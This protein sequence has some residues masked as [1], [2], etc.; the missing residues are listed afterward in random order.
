MRILLLL[1]VLLS[2]SITIT[3]QNNMSLLGHIDFSVT[4]NSGCSNLWGYVDETGKEYAIVGLVKGTSIV[5]ISDPANPMEVFFMPDST[6]TWREVKVWQDYAYI[7]TE[8]DAG[9]AIIDLSP[10]PFSTALTSY[11]FFG[12]AG[13][14]F[15]RAHSLNIDENGILY[16]HGADRGNG[17][18][19]F[20]DLTVDP[21]NPPEVGSYDNYYIHD[22]YARGDTLY[23][24][25]VYD[26]FFQVI[27]VSD[28]SNPVVLAQQTTPACFTH[29][30]WLSDD[31]KYLFTTDEVSNASIASYD[32]SDLG[33]ITELDQ[34]R[35]NPG[36]GSIP[37][38][39]YYLSG[40]WIVTSY[41]R[42]GVV[43]HDAIDPSN[44]I[45]V[46]QYDVSPTSGNGFSSVWGVYPYFPS[47]IIIAS[48][49]QTGLYIFSANYQRGAY[50]HGNVSDAS[51]GSDIYNA[52]VTILNT[53]LAAYTGINGNYQH[54][55]GSTGMYDVA[56][57]KPGYAR[58]TVYNVSLVQG[59]TSVLDIQLQPLVPISVSGQVTEEGSGL[60]IA[61]AIV[62]FTNNEFQLSVT[63]D[64]AGNYMIS[65]AFPGTY[66]LSSGHWG[67][68]NY[69][70]DS[71]VFSGP[72]NICNIQLK[73]GYY[74][75]FQLE[76]GWIIDASAT[77][78]NWTRATP[79]ATG[80][81][82]GTATNPHFDVMNDCGTKAFVTGN[83]LGTAGAA[84]VDGGPTRLSSPLFDATTYTD[85]WLAYSRWFFNNDGQVPANDTFF[86]YISNG[87]DTVLAE[88]LT[89]QNAVTS[90]WVETGFQIASLI[91]PT[92]NM[93]LILSVEDDL[94]AGANFLEAGIDRFY[95]SE[96]NQLAVALREN[97]GEIQV[98]P[99]P[100]QETIT[101]TIPENGLGKA[102][103]LTDISGKILYSGIIRLASQKL[104][105]S[106]YA[107]GIYI[108]RIE[109]HIPVKIIKH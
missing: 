89:V 74:D 103:L 13:N 34:V 17:G 109:N 65:D 6:S 98:Y 2:F 53:N 48:D 62:E 32:I 75:D 49:M 47:G 68:W 4:R 5:D 45:E 86:I 46:A 43:I 19:I 21:I 31:G 77:G 79:I 58:D 82:D 60:P 54:G 104:D 92:A 73:K 8:E 72:V 15:T 94:S 42:D 44:L 81:P 29:N 90:Q 9:M 10:L 101:I 27:D 59:D 24:A 26:G 97:N 36:S 7:T 78:G 14:G 18:A 70:N 1:F 80:L 35:S 20:Y 51:N 66:F 30:C 28:K 93:R 33:N 37:H 69:C 12:D 38:N 61:N 63:T 55:A 107:K 83:Q 99:N 22:S 108:L 56:F 25:H 52:T 67:H 91:L 41:Y 23:A 40:G 84:D 11:R 96:G 16:V 100:A 3:A 50:L 39:T 85:P 106:A 76:F 88:A 95:V 71:L 87:I 105:L 64:A 57:Y 102:M